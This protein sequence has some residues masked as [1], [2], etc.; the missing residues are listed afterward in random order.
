MRR[1]AGVSASG[2]LHWAD[3]RT[4]QARPKDWVVT[5]KETMEVGEGLGVPHRYCEQKTD[6]HVFPMGFH[7]RSVGITS[8][9]MERPLIGRVPY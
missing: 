7:G 3:L 5:M 8:G 9:S 1:H 6:I 4:S 2:W